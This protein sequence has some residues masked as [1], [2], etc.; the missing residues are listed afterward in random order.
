MP[1]GTIPHSSPLNGRARLLGGTALTVCPTCQRPF[2]DQDEAQRVRAKYER[3]L[4]GLAAEAKAAEQ[5]R[6]EALE[7][8]IEEQ[9]K[10]RVDA[11]RLQTET[12]F[13]ERRRG[14]VPGKRGAE[15]AG[16]VTAA[17]ARRADSPRTRRGCRN[18]SIPGART[19]YPGDETTRVP[20]GVAGGDAL[21]NV[22]SKDR[23]CGKILYEMKNTA[24]YQDF[25]RHQ[26]PSKQLAV[27]ADYAVLVTCVFPPGTDQIAVREN[28]EVILVH[29]KLVVPVTAI[30]RRLII[31]SKLATD[32]H[33]NR[34]AKREA[35]Y[36]LFTGKG[37]DLII[38][39]TDALSKLR[40]IDTQDDKHRR[41]FF[42]NREQIY[43]AQEGA[44]NEILETLDDIL[45]GD[46]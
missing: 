45:R 36:R 25:I 16:F 19:A 6:V 4:K 38:A 7:A 30:L 20:K 43:T 15:E 9:T 23:A 14:A 18:Q 5:A 32:S 13:A 2:E 41:Q 46:E 24:R 1:N 29:P 33:Q 21:L 39:A 8:S 22:V 37:R 40:G 26:A 10:E 27:K 35:V 44:L 12:K 17:Q 3:E 11:A 34:D 28:G 42:K 31:K